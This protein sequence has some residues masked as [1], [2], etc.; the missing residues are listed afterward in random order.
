MPAL[1]RAHVR[2]HESIVGGGEGPETADARGGF[3]EGHVEGVGGCD[4]VGEGFGGGQ[5]GGSG[6]WR[7]S[8]SSDS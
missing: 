6:A 3:E 1:I 2:V 7:I 5:A 4:V 8:V